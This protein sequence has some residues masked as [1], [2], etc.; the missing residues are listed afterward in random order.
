MSYKP[1]DW[2]NLTYREVISMLEY[3]R[4]RYSM[5]EKDLKKPVYKDM[6][7]M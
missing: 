1:K 2:S 5:K 3:Y 6:G 4:A 7:R